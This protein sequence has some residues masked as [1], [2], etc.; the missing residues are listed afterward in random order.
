MTFFSVIVS[1]TGKLFKFFVEK[2][3]IK[4]YVIAV[5]ISFKKQE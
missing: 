1:S 2:V 3:K 4:I 5:E